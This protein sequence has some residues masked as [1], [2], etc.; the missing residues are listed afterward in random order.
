M[1]GASPSFFTIPVKTL[2]YIRNGTLQVKP[3]WPIVI[4]LVQSPSRR[5]E[6]FGQSSWNS[7]VLWS[8]QSVCRYRWRVI[9]FFSVLRCS[10]YEHSDGFFYIDIYTLRILSTALLD[11]K[12]SCSDMWQLHLLASDGRLY[13]NQAD[14]VMKITPCSLEFTLD[15]ANNS[16][17]GSRTTKCQRWLSGNCLKSPIRVTF[18]RPGIRKSTVAKKED[19]LQGIVVSH[20]LLRCIWLCI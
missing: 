14:E 3:V 17:L 15:S 6:A 11:L 4:R 12:A 2:L 9:A 1:A 18:G 8:I 5:D 20:W 19:G 10:I 13:H 16:L 7:E